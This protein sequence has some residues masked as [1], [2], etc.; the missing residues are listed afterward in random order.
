MATGRT[1]SA[2]FLTERDARVIELCSTIS[3]GIT[4]CIDD[5]TIRKKFISDFGKTSDTR[6]GG[7]GVGAGKLQRDALC[8][9]GRQGKAPFSNRNLRWHPLAVAGSRSDWA[10]PISRIEIENDELLIF[11]V[12]ENG[13]T[14]K[15]RAD[16]AHEMRQRYAALPEFWVPHINTLKNWND[17]LWTQ[18]SCVIPILEACDWQDAVET[19]AVLG[20][21]VSVEFFGADF[22]RVYAQVTQT[23]KQQKIDPKVSL[24]S[25]RFPSDGNEFT[26]CPVCRVSIAKNAAQML[27]RA[28]TKVWQPAWRST[29]REEGEDSSIQLMH[30]EPLIESEPRHH[31]GNVRY[32]HRWCNVA[33]TDH[34]LDE[35]L[36]F[37]EYIVRVHNRCK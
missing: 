20:I 17:T 4:D 3:R 18:N 7:M 9:R 19:Y 8:T 5:A 32:G 11:I 10:Q 30:V 37:M 1:I 34:S 6:D 33:M 28:R 27:E 21:A 25:P 23:L 16:K 22:A 26:N 15:Y 31:A 29:K 12:K 35:T 36:D 24:P 13:R 2:S 14:K